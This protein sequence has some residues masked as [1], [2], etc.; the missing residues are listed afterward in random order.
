MTPKLSYF[1]SERHLDSQLRHRASQTGHSWLQAAAHRA[2]PNPTLET[3]YLTDCHLP[4]PLAPP[5]L[6]MP[7][8]PCS[9]HT[10]RAAPPMHANRLGP[11]QISQRSCSPWCVTIIPMTL[12]V[13]RWYGCAHTSTYHTHA[14]TSS[15]TLP[16]IS[17]REEHRLFP[18]TARHYWKQAATPPPSTRTPKP[19]K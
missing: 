9:K 16:H 13:N 5:P 6:T 4:Y 8:H 15:S 2:F 3:W 1:I 7:H 17:V 11:H 14:T 19:R 10:G 12:P 18:E